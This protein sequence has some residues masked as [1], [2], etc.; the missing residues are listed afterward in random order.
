[1][2]NWKTLSRQ[3]I[4]DQ[5]PYLR[6]ESHTIE[7]PNGKILNDWSWISTPDFVIIAVTTLEGQF[8]V[9]RQT[10]YAVQGTT[11]ATVGGYVNQGEDPLTAAKRELLEEAG[12][13]APVW[14]SLGEFAV[15]GSRGNGV[16]HLFLAREARKV[17]DIH[18]DDLE[19]QDMLL[20]SREELMAAVMRGAFKVLPWQALMAMAL[21]SS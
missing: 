16:A 10:K 18:S 8:L 7:L 19:E 13:E 21:L 15:D 9:F 1:M 4:L 3:V 12:Y 11:L 5:S 14:E 2:Q 20:L 6:V 17:T